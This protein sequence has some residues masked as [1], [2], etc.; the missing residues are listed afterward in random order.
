MPAAAISVS[1]SALRTTVTLEKPFIWF[2]SWRTKT[3]LWYD[4]NLLRLF[5]TP[6]STWHT[7]DHINNDSLSQHGCI[8]IYTY[9]HS[10]SDCFWD[11]CGACSLFIP[12]LGPYRNQA[13]GHVLSD[14]EVGVRV[15][16]GL[17]LPLFHGVQTGSGSTQ[18]P[19][20]WIPGALSSG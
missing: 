8:T 16:V 20:Q 17:R 18:L 10:F 12:M 5:G 4:Q 13:T 2:E 14:R 19:I 11:Y 1:F 6:C 3:N 7:C 15:Q 9:S